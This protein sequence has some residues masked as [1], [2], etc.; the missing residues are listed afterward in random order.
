LP[1]TLKKATKKQLACTVQ[2]T[3]KVKWQEEA[4]ES[5]P[6]KGEREKGREIKPEQI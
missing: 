2:S 1:G 5:C 6:N 4:E 3:V